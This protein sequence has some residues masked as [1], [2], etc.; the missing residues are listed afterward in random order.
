MGLFGASSPQDAA[1]VNLLVDTGPESWRRKNALKALAANEPGIRQAANGENLLML[2]HDCSP[3]QVAARVLV[4]TDI[5]VSTVSKKG[6]GLRLVYSDIAETRLFQAKQCM[7]VAVESH[8]SQRDFMPDD[9]RRQM[10][11]IQV[12]AATP[13]AA[14]AVC[15]LIDAGL[16]S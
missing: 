1:F 2:L 10:H 11:I 7:I 8:T 6:M 3:T 5:A 16:T 15:T 13:G 9:S 12:G 4:V 14:N